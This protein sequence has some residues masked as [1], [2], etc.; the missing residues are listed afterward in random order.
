MLQLCKCL[1]QCDQRTG[2]FCTSWKENYFKFSKRK[3]K[4]CEK[5]MTPS[6]EQ[7][8]PPLSRFLYPNY[9]IYLLS[10]TFS[11]WIL[12]LYFSNQYENYPTCFTLQQGKRNFSCFSPASVKTFRL[13]RE[14]HFEEN[15]AGKENAGP[16]ISQ[17]KNYIEREKKHF[18]EV[19]STNIFWKWPNKNL[20]TR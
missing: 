16:Q 5:F 19:W 7:L 9:R 14:V 12:L 1:K 8:S 6:D 3:K 10:F 20:W 13:I 4:R 2:R 17:F 11:A 15:K 18:S